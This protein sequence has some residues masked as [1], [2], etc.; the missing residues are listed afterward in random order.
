MSRNRQLQ[1]TDVHSKE[2]LLLADGIVNG[3]KDRQKQT[4]AGEIGVRRN[5]DLRTHRSK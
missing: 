1:S 5:L 4:K 2:L 3:P